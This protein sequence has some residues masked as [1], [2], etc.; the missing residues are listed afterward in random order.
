M[1]ADDII[2][3]IIKRIEWFS[4]DDHLFDAAAHVEL[5][6]TSCYTGLSLFVALPSFAPKLSAFC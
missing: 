2:E 3:M 4:L 1:C 5:L 6:V